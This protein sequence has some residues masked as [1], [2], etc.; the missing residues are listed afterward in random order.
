MTAALSLAPLALA[1][2]AA[3]T[4]APGATANDPDMQRAIQFQRA[5]DRADAQQAAKERRHPSI[6]YHS[7]D[8]QAQPSNTVKD[9][10]ERQWKKDKI[11][12]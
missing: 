12:H 4:P 2:D 3:T 6:S 8:R 9:P 7:A 11:V 5:K 1:Q 10:G